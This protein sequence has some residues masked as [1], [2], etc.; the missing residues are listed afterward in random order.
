[1]QVYF[2]YSGVE[3]YTL[4][5]SVYDRV[6]CMWQRD[7]IVFRTNCY[8]LRQMTS[9]VVSGQR[10][11]SDSGSAVLLNCSYSHFIIHRFFLYFVYIKWHNDDDDVT[12]WWWWWWW[13]WCHVMLQHTLT[14][15]SGKVLAAKFLSDPNHIVSGSHDR[16]LKLW[17]VRT[18]ACMSSVAYCLQW[19]GLF[20][21]L[22]M[23]ETVVWISRYCTS[24]SCLFPERQ[25]RTTL[26]KSFYLNLPSDNWN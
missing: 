13:W 23:V 6:V 5:T 12:S 7:G 9:Q 11:T 21:P 16:T 2:E 14:G 10:V 3:K 20:Y 15:H 17:D 18:T 24:G 19:L 8:W 26:R 4:R 1:M 22:C 25:R